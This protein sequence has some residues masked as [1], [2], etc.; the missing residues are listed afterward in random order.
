MPR[1]EAPAGG[2]SAH[3][4]ALES[5]YRSAAINGLFML[6]SPANWYFAIPGV[7]TTGPFNQH[8]VRD[9][10]LIF[11][12][13]AIA[14]LVGVA[15]PAARVALWSAAALW[16]S[17]HALFHFWEVAA[18]ICGADALVRDFPA[19]TLPAILTTA[20]AAWARRDETHAVGDDRAAQ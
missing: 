15:R 14:M 12:L 8:F 5:L 16:L 19:V 13:V 4:R 20:L 18:G 2:E 3:F 10:G 1:P 7:T 6:V 17:G 11:L 9:I